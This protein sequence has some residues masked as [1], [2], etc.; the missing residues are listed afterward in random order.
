VAVAGFIVNDKYFILAGLLV[1]V[2]AVLLLYR[3]PSVRRWLD[4]LGLRL[5]LVRQVIVLRNIG[6]FCRSAAMLLEA[7]LT[8]P[9]TL[10][11]IIGTV[12]SPAIRRALEAVREDLLKGRGLARPMSASPFFPALLVDMVGIGE[13][14]GTLPSA[15][16]A[17]ADLYEKKLDQRVRR[18][19]GMIE[20]A[21]I[22]AVGL[23]IAFIGIAIITP[24]YSIYQTVP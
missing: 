23:V 22:I 18:L 10:D 4:S 17:M 3:L 19:L 20:P 24:L 14:T 13:K 16:A 6:R 5:P 2:S 1:L 12:D 9:R 11:T 15:F 7:G 8:L 21:T